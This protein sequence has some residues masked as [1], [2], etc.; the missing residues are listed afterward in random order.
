M[1]SYIL[2][3]IDRD[4][5]QRLK[6]ELRMIDVQPKDLIEHLLRGWLASRQPIESASVEV[7]PTPDR[8]QIDR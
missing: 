8:R 1:P 3:H 6:A 7:R 5:W 2:R 4:L